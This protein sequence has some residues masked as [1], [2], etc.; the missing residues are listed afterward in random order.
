MEHALDAVQPLTE[1]QIDMINKDV[2]L[3]IADALKAKDPE[4]AF[5]YGANLNSMG[6]AV[7]VS[8]AHLVYEMEKLWGK[9]F[10]SDEKF[11][12]VAATR[13]NKAPETIRRYLEIWK[14]VIQKPE[15]TSS[16]L[17]QLLSKPMQGLWYIKQAAREGQLVDADWDKVAKAPDV[18]S[19]REIGKGIRG[20]VGRAKDALK[21]M[22]EDD[23][24]IKARRKGSY[25][26]VGF[27]NLESEDNVV[28]AAIE[29]IERK[30]GIFRR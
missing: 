5:S 6:Q 3:V 22:L 13:W 27:L 10:K 4:V 19:L 8:V 17:V 26:V 21:I 9:E 11:I 29:R 18:S 14:W 7:W 2:K 1:E 24:T 23:G 20:E 15:H 25:E 28:Q 30:A 12:T 16:R